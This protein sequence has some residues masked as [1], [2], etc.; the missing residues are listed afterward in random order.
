MNQ[1]K[2]EII[3]D[4]ENELPDVSM[5]V[6][7]LMHKLFNNVMEHRVRVMYCQKSMKNVK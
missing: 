5:L 7:G 1:K 3:P 6:Q 2:N 4:A